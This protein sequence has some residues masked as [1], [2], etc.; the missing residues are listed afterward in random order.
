[1]Q[2]TILTSW[3]QLVNKTTTTPLNL[4][5]GSRVGRRR[6]PDNKQYIEVKYTC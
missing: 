5:L 6:E 1:M 3:G 2:G 4:Y